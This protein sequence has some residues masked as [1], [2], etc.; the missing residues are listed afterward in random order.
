MPDGSVNV[1]VG[2]EGNVTVELESRMR[3]AIGLTFDVPID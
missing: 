1:K 3:K 2:N